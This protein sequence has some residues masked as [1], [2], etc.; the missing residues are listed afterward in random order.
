[1]VECLLAWSSPACG[2]SR[3]RSAS[4]VCVQEGENSVPKLPSAMD[5]QHIVNNIPV[6]IAKRNPLL[7][8]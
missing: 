5:T 3:L 8:D 1:M 6:Y 7:V 4:R 2:I